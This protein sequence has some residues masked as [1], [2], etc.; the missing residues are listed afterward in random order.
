MTYRTENW[1]FD[2][3][4]DFASEDRIQARAEEDAPGA[5]AAVRKAV[6]RYAREE[7]PKPS[8][9]ARFGTFPAKRRGREIRRIIRETMSSADL[10][11]DFV[12]GVVMALDPD[13]D[14]FYADCL[15]TEMANHTTCWKPLVR[16]VT[17]LKPMRVRDFFRFPFVPST[18]RM[19]HVRI[20]R[21]QSNR[22]T[23]FHQLEP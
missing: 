14:D 23:P 4:R 19:N 17:Q 16:C 7:F 12:C 6:I 18:R 8:K 1:L 15:M 21:N 22:G 3:D 9:T 5:I 2:D 10:L 11:H 20:L 13:G